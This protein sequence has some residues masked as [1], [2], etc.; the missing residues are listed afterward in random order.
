MTI[1]EA[2]KGCVVSRHRP[3]QE[4]DLVRKI[5]WVKSKQ[6]LLYEFCSKELLVSGKGDRTLRC[7]I[8]KDWAI[9]KKRRKKHKSIV[10]L[11]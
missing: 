4:M 7:S 11:S 9:R 5:L 8:N 3:K 6:T 10:V 2:E 1:D